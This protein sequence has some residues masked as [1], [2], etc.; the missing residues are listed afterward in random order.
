MTVEIQCSF[1]RIESW[2]ENHQQDCCYT[3]AVGGYRNTNRSLKSV[4][5]I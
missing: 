4:G 2:K 3:S 1:L 5:A